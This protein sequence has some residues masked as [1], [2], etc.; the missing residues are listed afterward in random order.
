MT[1]PTRDNS[2]PSGGRRSARI[3]KG[4]EEEVGGRISEAASVLDPVA[5]DQAD[6][7]AL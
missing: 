1:Q 6:A 3:R 4:A 5:A 7:L 2:T